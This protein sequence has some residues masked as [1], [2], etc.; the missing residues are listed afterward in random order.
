MMSSSEIVLFSLLLIYVL[1]GWL[2]QKLEDEQTITRRVKRNSSV[3][4]HDSTLS[5]QAT[6]D[7][8]EDSPP[9]RMSSNDMKKAL[10]QYLDDHLQQHTPAEPTLESHYSIKD[11]T[12]SKDSKNTPVYG[13][14]NW[15]SDIQ[16][17]Q[18]N[19]STFATI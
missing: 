11:E 9:S 1:N 18:M 4:P 6:I 3:Q 10:Q 2:E 13:L 14:E 7:D 15:G 8:V 12:Q 16:P 5:K 19:A 17:F